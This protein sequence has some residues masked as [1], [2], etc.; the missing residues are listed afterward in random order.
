MLRLIA[1]HHATTDIAEDDHAICVLGDQRLIHPRSN[2]EL[3]RVRMNLTMVCGG[4]YISLLR[5]LE[6]AGARHH[7]PTRQEWLCVLDCD[8]LIRLASQ[9]FPIAMVASEWSE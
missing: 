4:L 5:G 1:S 8:C 3:I 2:L 6:P 9:F 7:S